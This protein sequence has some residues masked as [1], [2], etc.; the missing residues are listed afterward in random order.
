M[1]KAWLVFL[2]GLLCVMLA[3]LVALEAAP[4]AEVGI[5][6]SEALLL[7][8]GNLKWTFAATLASFF[9]GKF[10]ARGRAS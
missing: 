5:P 1:S 4:Y 3:E 10:I 8:V 9:V 7:A 6:T 2:C